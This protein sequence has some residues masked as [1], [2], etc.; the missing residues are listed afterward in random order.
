MKIE[1]ILLAI[2]GVSLLCCYAF[3]Q[4]KKHYDDYV[5]RKEDDHR[6]FNDDRSKPYWNK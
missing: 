5:K 4:R 3:H 6:K 2:V 1:I